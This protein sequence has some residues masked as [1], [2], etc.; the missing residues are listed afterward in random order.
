[1]EQRLHPLHAHGDVPGSGRAEVVVDVGRAGNRDPGRRRV[2]LPRRGGALVAEA[3]EG[4]PGTPGRAGAEGAELGFR[5]LVHRGI[6]VVLVRVQALQPGVVGVDHLTG[7]G[8]GVAD[9]LRGGGALEPAVG[10]P[11]QHPRPAHRLR[12]VPGGDHL[13][14]RVGAELEVQAAHSRGC[15]GVP[16]GG[17]AAVHAGGLRDAGTG[18]RTKREAG[19]GYADRGEETA[20]AEPGTEDLLVIGHTKNLGARGPEAATRAG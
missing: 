8:V 5:A 15:E 13:A 17:V 14:A 2:A 4:E 10:A 20:A 1:V 9:G 19:T 3:G 11:E 12:R 7:L 6:H 18:E 16:H